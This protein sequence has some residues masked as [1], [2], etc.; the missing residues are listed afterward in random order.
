[1]W[2]G[3]SVVAE[4]RC[5]GLA[6]TKEFF[7]AI[8]AGDAARV[9]EMLARDRPLAN[10][11]TEAGFSA[12]IV[13]KLRGH[14]S[15]LREI[16]AA[17]PALD[18]HDVAYI[19]D[20]AHARRL[21]DRDPSLLES[22]SS[23]GFTALDLA[24]YFGHRE[25]AEFLLE[26]GAK[27]EHEIRN[28][29]LFTALTGAVA[30]GHL[31]IAKMLLDRG[32]NVNHRYAEGATP[33]ITASYNGD[34][35]LVTLLLAH[36]ARADVSN[37][38]GRTAADVAADRGH[39]EIV[40]MLRTR[41]SGMVADRDDPTR[42]S[43]ENYAVTEENEQIRVLVERLPPGGSVARHRHPDHLLIAIS[44]GRI[45]S[46]SVHGRVEIYELEPGD[47]LWFRAGAHEVENL[48]PD[49]WRAALVEMKTAQRR[50]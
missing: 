29:N 23:D 16:L 3:C 31:D 2:Q 41:P 49:P 33:L 10:A 36:G 27:V 22:F 19:G 15:V 32:A 38:E 21:L 18:V 42:V 1:M 13:A 25:L 46:R 45:A 43:P 44:G 39:G 50:T 17:N 9:R 7:D 30:E 12:V 40:T 8:R 47:A 4:G 24:S 34:E 6:V 28:E 48:G 14:D 26:R 37:D 20:V 35:R 5:E 11:K